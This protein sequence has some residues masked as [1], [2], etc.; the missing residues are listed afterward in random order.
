MDPGLDTPHGPYTV[1]KIGTVSVPRELLDEIGIA[2]GARVHWLL[3]PDLPG[4]L[5]LVPSAV[6]SHAM[7]ELISRLRE[8]G[9]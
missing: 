8:V 2:T 7:P 1:Q 4:T 6:L 3:N 5:V 9:H